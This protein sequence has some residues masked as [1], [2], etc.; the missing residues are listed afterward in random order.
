MAKTPCFFH[1]RV[2]KF[3]PICL[4]LGEVADVL[5]SSVTCLLGYWSCAKV[6]S[7]KSELG[8]LGTVAALQNW[9]KQTFARWHNPTEPMI[10]WIFLLA[11]F[12]QFTLTFTPSILL[13]EMLRKNKNK[14]SKFCLLISLF[15][16]GWSFIYF[17]VKICEKVTQFSGKG[18]FYF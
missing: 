14:S 8:I 17:L 16:F 7:L 4:V 2:A 9:K 12:C 3:H 1:K 13:K 11:T 6:C 5:S 15:L 10:Q 18:I